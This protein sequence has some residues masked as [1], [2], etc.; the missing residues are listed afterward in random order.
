MKLL[1]ALTIAVLLIAS[2]FLFRSSHLS[3]RLSSAVVT[4]DRKRS[5]ASAVYESKD[6]N[7]ILL[8]KEKETLP[9]GTIY[10]LWSKAGLAFHSNRTNYS[11]LPGLMFT[12]HPDDVGVVL[13]APKTEVEPNVVSGERSFAFTTLTHARVEVRW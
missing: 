11:V 6:G 5:I 1:I 7:L 13:G 2:F 4:C 9:E 10:L 3:S 8:L 12:W